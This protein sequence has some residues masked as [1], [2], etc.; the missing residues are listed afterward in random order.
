MATRIHYV[1]NARI[2][3]VR[4]Y[5]IQIAKMTE[6]L[7]E[8][9]AQV[10][11]VI[12]RTLA[13]HADMQQ[14]NGLRTPVRTVVVRGLDWS[15]KGRI[16]FFIGSLVF[17]VSSFIFLRS[18][19]KKGNV[20]AVYTVDMD[21]FSYA[22]L[23]LT[24]IPCF[25]EMH[26]AKRPSI[27]NRLFFKRARGVI[28]TNKEIE[29]SLTHTF[30]IPSARITVQPNGVDVAQISNVPQ[31]SEARAELGIP[32]DAQVALYA[33]RF[34]GWKGLEILPRAAALAHD[35]Q[36]YVIGGSEES[37]KQFAGVTELPE[38][39]HVAGDKPVDAIPK[40]LTSA[41]TLLILGTRAHEQS[42]RYTAPMKVYEYMAARRPIIAAGTPA[43]TGIIAESDALFYTPDDAADLARLVKNIVAIDSSPM[44]ERAF[45]SAIEHSWSKRAERVLS[46]VSSI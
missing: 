17:M 6:A 38:N 24:G 28:A 39:L 4:A 1:I 33:G 36:W 2:P 10:T 29:S 41:D 26:G 21:T 11:I 5:G 30:G 42:Y 3:H 22:L 40:W 35:I 34:Y 25:A 14:V 9:G 27:A 31:K 45:R 8:A 19:K 16:P 12:P 18:E 46:F 43:L 7:I 23:P 13:S 37:F 20:D 15:D 32:A 44:T